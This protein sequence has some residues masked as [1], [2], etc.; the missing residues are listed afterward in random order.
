M[1]E[2]GHLHGL[3]GPNGAGKTTL[4]RVLLGLIRRDAGTVRLLGRSLDALGGPI[5]DAVA[6]FVETPAF[7]P[8]PSG[9]RNLALLARLDTGSVR[10]GRVADVLEA[11]GLGP[12]ADQ[13]SV[14][15]YSA[16]MRQRLCLAAALLRSP[17]LLFLDE[18][19]NSLDPA[20]A[21]D[22]RA[23]ARMVADEDAAVVFSSHDMAEVE[24]LCT[25][26][27]VIDRGRVV[28]SGSVE[29][30]RRRAPSA[31]FA[32]RTSDDGAAMQLARRGRVKAIPGDACGL[33]LAADADALDEYV[34]ALG[35]A[36]IAVRAL[37]PRVR[38]LE[39]VFLELTSHADAE[40]P[41]WH[42]AAERPHESPVLS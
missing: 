19:T 39:S 23:L 10:S 36:G 17:Q 37:E 15:G 27:T 6:G 32:L 5:P 28:F 21:R 30:F 3:L 22:V 40:P 33:E 11:T 34:I 12:Q 16:G 42:D 25:S 1:A 31:M 38:S 29:E 14:S 41:P 9:R 20:G 35:R 18:P 8:Y 24:E 7:Y 4:L 13:D 26:L 2:H